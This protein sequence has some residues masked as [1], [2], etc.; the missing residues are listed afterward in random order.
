VGAKPSEEFGLF[1]RESVVI[2]R[3]AGEVANPRT[4]VVMKP[5]PLDGA[6]VDDPYDRRIALAKWL[7]SP[8]NELFAKSVVNRYVSYLLGRGLVDPVDDLRATNPPSNPEL[9][10]ALAKRFVNSGFDLKQLIRVIMASRLYQLDSQPT[11]ANASDQCFYS[12][13]H[14]KRISAEA[15]LDAVDEAAGTRT[16][17]VN[18]P[19]GTRAIELPDVEYQNY[20]LKTFGKPVRASVC[21]C[22]RSPDENL[23]QALHTLNGDVVTEKIDGPRGRIARLLE[24]KSSREKIVE[25]IYLATLARFP[26]AAEQKNAARFLKE[27]QS[28]KECYE[29]LQWAL[30]NSK[31]FLFNH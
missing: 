2:V 11:R 3:Q 19:L 30:V 1:G 8:S 23:A 7:T 14:V 15:L 13:Y 22:E 16:K 12:H 28:A 24:A 26:T 5:K 27:S 6:A 29:D 4:G 31:E 25:D 18:M 10:D 20:F 17:F 21:E 9:M